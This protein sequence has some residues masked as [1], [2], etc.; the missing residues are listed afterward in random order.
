MSES[1][2]APR[3][4]TEETLAYVA[5]GSNLG[6]REAHF[7][8]ALAALASAPGVR[9]LR[10]SR[11]HETEPVGGPRGQPR[12][13]NGVVEVATTLDVRTFFTLLQSL[14]RRAGRDRASEVRHGPRTLDLDLL[15]FGERRID[16]HDLV[17]PH[18]RM[19]EREFVLAPLADL[20]PE[21]ARRHTRRAEDPVPG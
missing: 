4:R 6:P 5:F 14:E 15:L 10:R 20:S 9:V 13:L 18:P 19:G 3:A 21:L 7:E 11:W 8:R 2:G 12:F 16:E 1:A 17:V